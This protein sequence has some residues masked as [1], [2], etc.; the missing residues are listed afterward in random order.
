MKKI[1]FLII[2]VY[3]IKAN[4]QKDSLISPLKISGYLETYYSY[5]FGNPANHE[6]PSFFYN[7]NRHN[8]AN[9]NLGYI[10]A[11]YDAKNLRANFGLMEGTWA[12]YNSSAEQSLLKNLWQANVGVKLC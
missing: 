7:F 9:L 6:R 5:D 10:N 11:S 4:A 3:A 8:E 12:Q 2:C 1:F